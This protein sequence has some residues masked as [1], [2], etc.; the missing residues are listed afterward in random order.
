M[1]LDMNIC[2]DTHP[3]FSNGVVLSK[4]SYEVDIFQKGF[5]NICQILKYENDLNFDMG[6]RVLKG[7]Q[8]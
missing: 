6:T 2:N 8:I 1:Y 3:H 4:Y 7:I 5:L